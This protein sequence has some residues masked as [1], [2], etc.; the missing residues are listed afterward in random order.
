MLTLLVISCTSAFWIAAGI[1]IRACLERRPPRALVEMAIERTLLAVMVTT[2][3]V[4]FWN[5]DLGNPL[6]LE[7]ETSR[8]I[9]R[10][11]VL[12]LVAKPILFIGFYVTNSFRDAAESYR[13]AGERL[14]R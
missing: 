4:L 12:L 3:A 13:E 9:A 8:T 11:A 2:F 10:L 5:T 1:T 14:S 7:T 6:R